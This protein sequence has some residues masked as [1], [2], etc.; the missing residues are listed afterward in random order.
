MQ[1]ILQHGLRIQ[2]QALD[3]LDPDVARITVASYQNHTGYR[4]YRLLGFKEA[5]RWGATPFWG[6]GGDRGASGRGGAP[7]EVRGDDAGGRRRVC[8]G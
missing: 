4:Y 6:E 3:R 2:M 7:V 8:V 1:H 5:P